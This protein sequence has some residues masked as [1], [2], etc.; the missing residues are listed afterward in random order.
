MLKQVQRILLFLLIISCGKDD[1][2][3]EEIA[4]IPVE[5][6][7]N[8]FD[9]RFAN[10]QADSLPQLKEE[11]PYLF[12]RIYPNIVW[13]EKM[14][15][16]I[17]KEIN[18]EV[19]KEFSDM[20]DVEQE[21]QSLFQHILFYFP[22]TEIPEVIT[23]TSDVDYR[24]KVVWSQGL[25]LIALDT[26]LGRE[27]HFYAGIQQYI[28][29]N[30]EREQIVPDVAKA[31]AESVVARP[32][33]RSFLAHMIY[34][35]KILYL[36][37]A[38]IPF[39]SDAQIIGYTQEELDWAKANEEQIWRYFV[40]NELLFSSDADLQSR[41]LFPGPFSKFR[42]E[43]DSESPAQLGQYIGWQMVRTYVEKSDVGV[44]ELLSV[45]EETIFNESNYKPE[46]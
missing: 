16:T 9:Q 11:Y 41:F 8:R 14:N 34:Y 28:K 23:V 44:K 43:L 25:L 1:K 31:F 37:E 10:A 5:V 15:D 38:L 12:P 45:D 40:E 35:G 7:I 19:D 18:V 29:K 21:L 6:E 36:K 33:K 46:K 42:L 24:S 13:V 32:G 4:A 17:Q 27:H 2:R 3:E 39:K 22:G 30:F 26:Y 20:D